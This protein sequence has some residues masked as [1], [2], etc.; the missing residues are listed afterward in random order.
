MWTS[1][2][3]FPFYCCILFLLMSIITVIQIRKQADSV[4]K[5]RTVINFLTSVLRHEER[6][7]QFLKFFVNHTMLTIP[8]VRRILWCLR[9]LSV[10]IWKTPTTSSTAEIQ[11]YAS[12]AETQLSATM[13]QSQLL[14]WLFFKIFK[15]SGPSL[16]GMTSSTLQLHFLSGGL[17]WQWR[18]SYPLRASVKLH[19]M[20]MHLNS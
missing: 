19:P 18:L 8:N 6:E 7:T 13:V 3:E 12:M 17:L 9:S 11:L 10:E 4:V 2:Q 14:N 1:V 20:T 16:P 5:V 15:F